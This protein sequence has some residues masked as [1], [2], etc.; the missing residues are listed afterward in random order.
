MNISGLILI[1]SLA[2]NQTDDNI[3]KKGI[4]LFEH[5][6]YKQSITILTRVVKN[7][8]ARDENELAECYKYLGSAYFYL[9]DM[10]LADANFRQLLLLK[11][12][13]KLDPFLF[14]PSMVLFFDKIKNEISINKT[15][16]KSAIST[17]QISDYPYQ[18][19]LYIN[20]LPFGLP[21]FANNQKL[22]A[23]SILIS[24]ILALSVNIVA[25]W[26]VNSMI[27]KNGYVKDQQTADRANIYKTIQ[28]SSLAAFGAIYIYSVIDGFIFSS[29]DEKGGR[30]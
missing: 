30:K 22:K 19:R 25:Y 26:Q 17:T 5:G 10:K 28:V 18:Y 3:V 12:D 21:Q 1:L 16:A 27:D 9:E 2:L 14:P 13:F 4:Y 29:S 7:N 11:P 8:L 6:D 15:K 24:Q 20:L 23:T